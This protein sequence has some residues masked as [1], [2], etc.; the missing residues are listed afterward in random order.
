[1][2]ESPRPDAPLPAESLALAIALADTGDL[3]DAGATL[4]IG[5][6][7]A[8]ARIAQL[9]REIGVV[10]F[11]HGGKAVSLTRAGEVFISEAR[12]SLAAAARA[13]RLARD[14]AERAETIGIGVTDDAMIGPLADLFA[15]PAWIEAGFQPRLFHGPLDRQMAAL[16]EGEVALV[17]SAPPLPAHPRIQHKEIA[18]SRWSAVVPDAEARLRKTASLS[19]L[20]RKP[21]VMLERERA[22][23]AHDG[24]LAALQATGAL[25]QVAQVAGSWAG[26]LAMVALGLGSALVPSIVAKRLTLAGATVLPLVEADDLPPWTISVLW[27]PQPTGTAA[28]EAIGLVKSRLG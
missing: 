9:E 10:L 22:A 6:R 12:L 14:V 7:T 1:M 23:L 3:G 24:V 28:A 5:K 4:G 8:A 19:N 26:V 27:L 11:D 16:A 2:A 17:F 15:D 25:P 21:L 18:V 13:A 20:A